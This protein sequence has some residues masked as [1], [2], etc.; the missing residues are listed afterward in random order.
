MNDRPISI[1]TASAGLLWL[2]GYALGIAYCVTGTQGMGVM[3]MLIVAA[4]A[5]LTVRGYLIHL[6]DALIEREGNAYQLGR[7]TRGPHSVD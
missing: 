1:T 2:L 5:T 4:G 7:D 6:A 3:A